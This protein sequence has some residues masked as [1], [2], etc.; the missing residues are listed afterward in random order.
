MEWAWHYNTQTGRVVE[1]YPIYS[2][3]Q[4]G[5]AP[6]AL[7]GLSAV[8]GEDFS[9]E[10]E[11]GL[12]WIFG[13]NPL[14]FTFVDPEHAL[15]W[16]SM[17]RKF[18][19]AKVIYLNKFSSFI[20]PTEWVSGLDRPPLLTIDRECRPYELGWLLFSFADIPYR[21]EESHG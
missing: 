13:E 18:P 14:Q 17:K 20:G 3:H 5:M 6:L 2:V 1:P 16:R 4:H 15:I 8:S 7:K 19:L 21:K 10:V 11:R 9:E 12:Q